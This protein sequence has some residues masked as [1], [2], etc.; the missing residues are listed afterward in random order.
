MQWV[1]KQSYDRQLVSVL[2]TPTPALVSSVTNGQLVVPNN[3]PRNS[4]K[5]E[6]CRGHVMSAMK[7]QGPSLEIWIR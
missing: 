1:Y 4:E 6:I 3:L 2:V 5:I 7:R